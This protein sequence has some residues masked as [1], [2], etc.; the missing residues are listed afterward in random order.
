MYR[1]AVIASCLS[2]L[3]ALSKILKKMPF[4]TFFTAHCFSPLLVWGHIQKPIVFFLDVLES[5]K[6]ICKFHHQI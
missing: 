5:K 6:R 2:S 3:I 4:I 1:L